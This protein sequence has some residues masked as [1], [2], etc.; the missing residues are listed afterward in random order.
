MNM[1]SDLS[2]VLLEFCGYESEYNERTA[3]KMAEEILRLRKELED[4]GYE[5][6]EIIDQ[7]S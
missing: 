4:S 3:Q 2:E 6:L 7:F 1:D 5:I